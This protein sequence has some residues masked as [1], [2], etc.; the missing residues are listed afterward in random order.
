M[1][2]CSSSRLAG[3]VLAAVTATLSGCASPPELWPA[4]TVPVVIAEPA[5]SIAR[6]APCPAIDPAIISET[7]RVT[8]IGALREGEALT[9]ALIG[10]EAAKNASLA[11]LARAYEKC[12]RGNTN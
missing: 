1:D 9:A 7:R 3:A 12:R 2:D 6:R 5:P 4:G 8:P 10:S 11:R